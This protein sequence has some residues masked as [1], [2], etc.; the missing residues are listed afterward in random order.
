MLIIVKAPRHRAFIFPPW[1]V[2]FAAPGRTGLLGA[3]TRPSALMQAALYEMDLGR[4]LAPRAK[5]R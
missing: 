5:Q 3:Q 2:S 4:R 1:P